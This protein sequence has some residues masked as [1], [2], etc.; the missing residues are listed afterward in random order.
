MP[1]ELRRREVEER[2]DRTD[3]TVE[4]PRQIEVSHVRFEH[5]ASR[6]EPPAREL[7]H[8]RRAVDADDLTTPIGKRLEHASTPAAGLENG[9]GLQSRHEPIRLVR[10]VP[11]EGDVV[12][13]CVVFVE[14]GHPAI[15]KRVGRLR[16]PRWKSSASTT[17]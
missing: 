3:R 16:R 1:T 2:V 10:E 6:S 5:F 12:K 11:V 4:S 8:P 13:F 17:M 7:D 9:G 14:P 15:L